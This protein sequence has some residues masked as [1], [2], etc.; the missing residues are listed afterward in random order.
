MLVVARHARTDSNLSPTNKVEKLRGW[1]P[2]P[3]NQEGMQESQ[4]LADT[5][6]ELKGSVESINSGSH[7]R[8]VQTAHEIGMALNHAIQP[9]DELNDLNTG[10]YAGQVITPAIIKQLHEYYHEPTRKI[11]EGESVQNW[12]ARVMHQ[13]RPMV[14]SDDT[15][16]LVTSGRTAN[17]ILAV[18]KNK[19]LD[20]DMD[21]LLKRPLIDNA[22]VFILDPCWNVVFKTEKGQKQAS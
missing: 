20:P 5:L 9:Q 13:V 6:S 4:E 10:I 16:V 7:P 12:Q 3:L 22:G 18:A 1:L 2:I 11:P 21:T 17:L 15:H 8:H 19:G 14:T